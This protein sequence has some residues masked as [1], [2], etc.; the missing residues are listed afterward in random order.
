MYII[1]PWILKLEISTAQSH[2][3]KR[4]STQFPVGNICSLDTFNNV[5]VTRSILKAGNGFN[6]VSF[7]GQKLNRFILM[8]E[9]STFRNS[10]EEVLS[11]KCLQLSLI[12]QP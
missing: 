10:P 6:S 8:W 12:Q 4:W 2:L 5:T 3:T 9:M 11:G 7:N 1:N